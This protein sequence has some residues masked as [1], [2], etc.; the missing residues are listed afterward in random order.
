MARFPRR[1]LASE[2]SKHFQGTPEERILAARRLGEEAL[3]HYLA[4]QPPGITREQARR[5]LQRNKN[6]GRLHSTVAEA[7]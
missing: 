4:S 3:D 5:L 1:D 7:E 2:A 6:R